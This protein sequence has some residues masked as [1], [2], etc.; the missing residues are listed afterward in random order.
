MKQWM[1]ILPVAALILGG[2]AACERADYTADTRMGANDTPAAQERMAAQDRMR[3][4]AAAANPAAQPATP[5]AD[6]QSFTGKLDVQDE[7]ARTF[8]LEG[9]AQTYVAP[10]QADLAALDG[11]QVNVM[12]DTNGRVISIT[13]ADREG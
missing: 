13:M 10:Q 4:D 2:A 3:D 12:L 1:A 7:D 6:R 9:N 11:E 8:I 5:G